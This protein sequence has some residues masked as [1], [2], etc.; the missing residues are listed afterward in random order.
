[1]ADK[2]TEATRRESPRSRV[3]SRFENR[4]EDAPECVTDVPNRAANV[5]DD[6]ADPIEG[7]RYAE[8]D[9]VADI[10]AH[11][12]RESAKP[13]PQRRY[14]SGALID[15]W[16]DRVVDRVIHDRMDRVVDRILDNRVNRVPDR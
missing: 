16:M 5:A 13:G 8:S 12:P 10:V 11:R 2:K 15:D 4:L 3:L 6:R 1:M 9:G 7:R 14:R